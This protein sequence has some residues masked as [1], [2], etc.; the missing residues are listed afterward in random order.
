[1]KTEN[2]KEKDAS[3]SNVGETFEADV[4]PQEKRCCHGVVESDSSVY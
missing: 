3:V 2:E 4:V 1:M